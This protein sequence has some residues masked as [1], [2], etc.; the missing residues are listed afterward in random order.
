MTPDE[1]SPEERAMLAARRHATMERFRSLRRRRRIG[2]GIAGVAA[3]VVAVAVPLTVEGAPHKTTQV[4]LSSPT[5]SKPPATGPSS[6][7][8]DASATTTTS[9]T[10]S[11]VAPSTTISRPVVTKATTPAPTTASTKPVATSTT[12]PPNCTAGQY[13]GKVTTDRYS[14]SRGQIVNITVT[15]TNT[16]PT[17]EGVPPWFCGQEAS[18]YDSSGNDVWDWGAGPDSPQDVKSCPAASNQVIPHGA[19]DTESMQWSQDRCTFEPDG[20]PPT[21]PNPD[22]PGTQ[23]PS[24]TYKVVDDHD[25]AWA[26]TIVL[27]A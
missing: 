15:L 11:T 24:G 12:V 1:P 25:M 14:Y 5:A 18:A 4:V 6:T 26:A 10:L 3:V 13:T 17:C 27:S 21:L 8:K 16:G 9:T 7:L 22:C 23:V 19:S 20:Q 2:V